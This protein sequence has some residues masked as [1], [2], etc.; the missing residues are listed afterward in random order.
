MLSAGLVTAW[1]SDPVTAWPNREKFW[2]LPFELASV[3]ARESAHENVRYA[4]A[5]LAVPEGRGGPLVEG[6]RRQDLTNTVCQ[7]HGG[8]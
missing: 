4:R 8:D 7:A 5:G 3:A 6:P 1:S 2:R